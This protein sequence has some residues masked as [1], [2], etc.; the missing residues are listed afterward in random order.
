MKKNILVLMGGPSS[1]H[2]ISLKSGGEVVKNLDPQKYNILPLI[3]PKNNHNL[4]L[5]LKGV[6][7]NIDVCFIALHGSFGEDGKVQAVLE[8]MGI[9]YTGSGVLASALGMDKI[10]SRQIFAQ[11][12]LTVPQTIVLQKGEKIPTDIKFPVVVKPNDQGSSVGVYIVKNSQELEKAIKEIFT[13]TNCVLVE[14]YLSGTEVTCALLGNENPKA[15]PVI[16]IVPK[17]EFFDL[18]AKYNADK[19]EEIVPAR[20]SEKLT[21]EVQ[22]AAITAFKALGCKGIGRIDAI[23]KD[24][25]VYVLEMNTIPGMTPTSLLPKAAKAADLS[26]S[27]LLDQIIDFTY[28]NKILI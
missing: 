23:I 14:E 5:H 21:K 24:D 2:G 9:K 20:I 19:C 28:Q 25:K 10:K 4:A 11:N 15:L 17:T 8:S 6:A 22:N 18:E 7:T 27:K 13:M 16:E 1:E 12:G 26:F 3:L